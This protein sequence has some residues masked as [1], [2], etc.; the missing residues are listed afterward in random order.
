M[1]GGRGI[2]GGISVGQTDELGS[3]AVGDPFAVKH[4]HATV[5]QQLGFDL[6]RLSYF[7]SVLFIML[8]SVLD[9]RFRQ[10]NAAGQR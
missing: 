10:P 6:N 4:L 1:D 9:F 7:Y 8:L 3:K 2:K 5:L